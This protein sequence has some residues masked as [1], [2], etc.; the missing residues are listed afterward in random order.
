MKSN[1]SEVKKC[2]KITV[3]ENHMKKSNVAT[4]IEVCKRGELRLFSSYLDMELVS[5][6]VLLPKW[7]NEELVPSRWKNKQIVA[8]W[9]NQVI[10]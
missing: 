8:A 9:S 2:R 4:Y 1:A 6:Y 7:N 5:T 10:I 3:F